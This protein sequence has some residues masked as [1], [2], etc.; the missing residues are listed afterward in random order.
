MD[1]YMEPHIIGEASPNKGFNEVAFNYQAIPQAA[2]T[3]KAHDAMVV[4]NMVADETIYRLLE[5]PQSGLA[6]PEYA[7]VPADVIEA[8]KTRGRLVN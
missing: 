2:A 6:E 3:T 5:H 4:S 8:W 1:E 7:V